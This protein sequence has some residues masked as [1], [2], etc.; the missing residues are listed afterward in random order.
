MSIFGALG[1]SPSS[2]TYLQQQIAVASLVTAIYF[3]ISDKATYK[4]MVSYRIMFVECV[5]IP[6]IRYNRLDLGDDI[7]KQH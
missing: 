2:S 3:S 7:L 1:T 6:Q 5:F 4:F